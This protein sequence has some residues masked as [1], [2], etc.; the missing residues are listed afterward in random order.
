[1]FA[2]LQWRALL[3][4]LK[5]VTGTGGGSECLSLYFSMNGFTQH[6]SDSLFSWTTETRK[7][8]GLIFTFKDQNFFPKSG[9]WFRTLLA[10]CFFPAMYFFHVSILFVIFSIFQKHIKLDFPWLL[11]NTVHCCCSLIL[12]FSTAHWSPPTGLLTCVIPTWQPLWCCG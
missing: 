12:S 4:Q 10:I 11:P 3:L 9:H 7:A 5:V 1:M 6:Y 2:R 8:Q